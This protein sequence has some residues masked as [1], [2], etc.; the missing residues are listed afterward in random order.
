MSGELERL[1]KS[2][3]YVL[4]SVLFLHF[5]AG[6][7]QNHKNRIADGSGRVKTRHHPNTHV[8]C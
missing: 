6:C 4:L 2:Y 5:Y 3:C 7:K 1:W 8:H